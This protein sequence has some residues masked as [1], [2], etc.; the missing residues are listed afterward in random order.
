MS[1]KSNQLSVT[2]ILFNKDY[3]GRRTIIFETKPPYTFSPLD[4]MFINIFLF[5]LY[6]RELLWEKIR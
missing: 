5:S 1:K 3:T 2:A 4:H 6:K